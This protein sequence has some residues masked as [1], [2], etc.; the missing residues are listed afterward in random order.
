MADPR[1]KDALDSAGK[2]NA[3]VKG[4]TVCAACNSVI[5][6]QNHKTCTL[7]SK[8]VHSRTACFDKDTGQCAE[9]KGCRAR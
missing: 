9:G 4:V 6:T 2:V 7:C 1:A 8:H 3:F 5:K